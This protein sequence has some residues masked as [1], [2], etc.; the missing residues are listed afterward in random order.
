MS[1]DSP[2]DDMVRD[3]LK[4]IT[5]LKEEIA[6]HDDLYYNRNNPQLS[7]Y[8]YDNLQLKLRKLQ[9]QYSELLQSNKEESVDNGNYK[10]KQT[11]EALALTQVGG[12]LD[13][14][15]PKIKHSYPMLS[16]EN[17]FSVDEV[18]SFIRKLNNYKDKANKRNNHNL[19][20]DSVNP[21]FDYLICE[22]KIDG[23][24][25]SAIYENGIF[26][27]AATR[28]NGI[29][30]EDIT[31]N[32][33]E[34]VGMPLVV[35]YN[36]RFEV[37]GEV[38][39]NKDDFL[40]LNNKRKENNEALF[41]NPR[42]AAAG[43]LRQLDSSITAQRNL[44]YMIWGGQI[45]EIK[46]QFELLQLVQSLGFQITQH[47]EKVN[48]IENLKKYYEMMSEIRAA[49]PYDIDGVVYKID[50]LSVQ[51]Q[52]GYVSKFPRWAIAHKF[53]GKEAITQIVDIIVQVSRN[54]TLTPVAK[55]NPVNIGGVLVT[56]ASLHNEEEIKRQDFR[57]GDTVTVKRAGDVIPK[58]IKVDL[59]KR[60]IN[61]VQ[62][63][64]PK[65]CPECG[66]EV[67]KYDDE[68]AQKCSGG[69][70]CPAQ[71]IEKLKHFASLNAFNIAGLGEQQ[72]KQL[73]EWKI[74]TKPQDLY[75]LKDK[76]NLLPK[77]QRLENQH[78]WGSKS[79]DNLFK[80]IE[81]SISLPL[82]NF[83]YALGIRYIGD[84]NSK[85]I[86]KHF[87][88]ISNLLHNAINQPMANFIIK[89]EKIKGIGSKA[90]IE[91]A[92]F[93]ENKNNLEMI[94][95]LKNYVN[96]ITESDSDNN[97]NTENILIG[98][99]IAFT[100]SM[101]NQTRKEAEQIAEKLGAK[102]SK[103]ISKQTSYIV[104]G[105]DPGS[106]LEQAQKFEN[107]KILTE[108]EWL[109]LLETFKV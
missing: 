54:G 28:G 76:N 107:I 43:S 34:V 66:S 16:L 71:V 23:L 105:A 6:L 3:L 72:I 95:E 40:E 31:N 20:I 89:L 39:M 61:S 103:T 50:D 1:I 59:S 82:N 57:I 46:T 53:P 55:L 19:H 80:A 2:K 11:S 84:Q 87:K 85:L 24:S 58:V 74:L 90:A 47:I 27:Y 51:K 62:Y 5:E 37:R 42:N 104:V 88:N 81:R 73:Y 60:P 83:I 108:Q 10:L 35:T 93:F 97:E 49:L 64:L 69:L 96:I 106:K 100:G 48:N 45:E 8:D 4:E 15:F 98:K 36:K 102:I 91:F 65:N 25:F 79:T 77:E 41:A 7:D 63:N 22:P 29:F 38:Y 26:Q 17:A 13:N 21:I 9:N 78:N 92:K 99:S 14:R 67:V 44:R 101:Y 12:A 70:D 94:N 86:A 52:L 56:R 33:K 30:G 18:L 32:I 75:T 68:V 109:E